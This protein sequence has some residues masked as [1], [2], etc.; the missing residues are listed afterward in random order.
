NDLTC[1][2]DRNPYLQGQTH[3]GV[4]V[5]APED[6]PKEVATVIAGLNPERA[7][8]ILSSNVDWLPATALIVFLE[9]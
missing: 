4:P 8:D 5:L 3:L 2:L 1:F 6:C 9:G 7:R